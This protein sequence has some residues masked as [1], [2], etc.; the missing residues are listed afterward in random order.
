VGGGNAR[1]TWSAPP[2]RDYVET[3]GIQRDGVNIGQSKTTTYDDTGLKE[4]VTYRYRVS[5]SGFGVTSPMS[6]ESPGSVIT[7]PDVTPPTVTATSPAAGVTG[8]TPTSA[9]TATFSE[10]IDATTVSSATLI[11]TTSAGAVIPGTLTYIAASTTAQFTPADGYPSGGTV[12]V[13]LTTGIKD[14]AGNRLASDFRFSFTARDVTPPTVVAVSPPNGATGVPPNAPL[15]VTFSKPMDASA[16]NASTVL[17][18]LA[19][20]GASV[21]ATVTYDATTLTATISPTASLAYATAYT[22]VVST[23]AK[24]PVGNSL[25]AAFSSSFA[26]S[27][28]PDTTAPAVVSV[29]P[30]DNAAGV[31]PST[32]VVVTFTESLQAN[33]INATTVTLVNASTSALVASSVSYDAATNTAALTPSSALSFSTRYAFGVS[34]AVKD[35]AGNQ[36]ASPFAS[37]FTT[38]SQPDVTAPAVVSV[39]PANLSSGQSVSSV[40]TVTFSEPMNAQ[41]IT[42]STVAVSVTST[43][44]PVAGTVSYSSGSNT[45]TFTPQAPLAFNTSYTVTVS[46]ATDV[47]GNPLAS[48]F[49]SVFATASAPD[50]TPPTVLS[51]SPANGAS[52]VAPTVKPTVTFSEQMNASTVN[53]STVTLVTSTGTSVSGSVIYDVASNTA[54]FA[55]ASALAFSTSYKLEVSG[56]TDLAGNAVTPSYSAT[57]S[58]GSPPDV[59]PPSVTSSVPVN[60]ATGVAI[61]VTPEATF[62][63]PMDASTI[64]A[65]TVTLVTSG[66][67]AVPGTVMYHAQ[68]N[69]V[70]FTPAAP[71]SYSTVYTLTVSTAVRDLAANAM[72]AAFSAQFTTRAPPDG[73]QPEVVS[74]VRL[75]RTGGPLENPSA[76]SVTF[77]EAMDPAT[78]NGSTITL[79]D[80]NN[81][82]APVAGTVTY[83]APTY[84][85][86][87]TAAS[88]LGYFASRTAGSFTLNVSTATKDLA[89]NDLAYAWWVSATRLGYWQ[90]TTDSTAS[91]PAI[92]HVHITFTQNGQTLTLAPDCQPLPGASCD[93]LPKNQAG[94]DAVGPLDDAGVT[95]GIRESSGPSNDIATATGGTA[96]TITAVTGT[97]T[98][99]GVTFTFTLANGRSFTFTGTMID[100]DT[101]TGT[102]SGAT[103][104]APMAIVIER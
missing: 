49:T 36:L 91:N 100:R 88:P 63:E 53:T 87:F 18:K 45:A 90:G 22:I 5:A 10:P 4:G 1:V 65:S 12:N 72:A 80:D 15:T 56:A 35:L 28:A 77:S 51:S 85:A 68:L 33:S 55:P 78:I 76:T 14:V 96:A 57:F 3:Y 64:N 73:I 31:S 94:M 83:D 41:T 48:P 34:S 32:S 59:T 58:T 25:A 37:S 30:P 52:N 79:N 98:N 7:V 47:A 74:F 97:F 67:T 39:T 43:G 75:G 13:T 21:P 102:L 26:T 61:T 42:A 66:G 29:S 95:P 19:S 71:L 17:L 101:M 46:G 50:T 62:S 104:I 69:M 6:D 16:V 70:R 27:A 40:V 24:D 44:A 20:T 84:T 86:T 81:G 60:G 82:G 38:A 93:V 92:I 9:I 89:G 103:L 11:V 2:E 99:P 54:T 8:V 23:G